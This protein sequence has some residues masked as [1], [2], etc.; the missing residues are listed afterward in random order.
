MF[1]LFS[2][3]RH[4]LRSFFASY[5]LTCEC[6]TS[7]RTRIPGLS[8]LSNESLRVVVRNHFFIRRSYSIRATIISLWRSRVRS[9]GA[10]YLLCHLLSFS[11]TCFHLIHIIDSLS[12]LAPCHLISSLG[13]RWFTL[14]YR[15]LRR[16]SFRSR[17]D[18]LF[19]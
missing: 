13:F 14:D 18:R 2:F 3:L 10:F 1:F 7:D 15:L 4:A 5:Y 6:A 9:A 17:V 12:Y 8:I 19:M 16:R 11:Y